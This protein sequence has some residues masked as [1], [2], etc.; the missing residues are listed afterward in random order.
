MLVDI[1][2]DANYDTLNVNIINL[3]NSFKV[4]ER[5]K[6]SMYHIKKNHVSCSCRLL[7][8]DS[9]HSRW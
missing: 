3:V 9:F 1:D 7:L 4:K 8:K 6:E 2:T 5:V